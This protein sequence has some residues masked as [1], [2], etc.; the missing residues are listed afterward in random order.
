MTWDAAARVAQAQD[1]LSLAHGEISGLKLLLVGR[2]PP[3]WQSFRMNSA[4][5]GKRF[6]ASSVFKGQE[7]SD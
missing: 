3:G 7:C 6:L 1:Q 4:R 2:S 5:L